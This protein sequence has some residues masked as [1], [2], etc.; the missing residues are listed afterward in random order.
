MA[1]EVENLETIRKELVKS[2]REM[3]HQAVSKPAMMRSLIQP[4]MERQSQI[5]AVERM[6]EDEKKFPKGS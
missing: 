5:D 1:D 4:L 3:A 6:I 2:R